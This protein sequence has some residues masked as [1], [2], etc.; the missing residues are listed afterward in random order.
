[1][2]PIRPIDAIAKKW[3]EVTPGRAAQYE[4]GVRNPVRNYEQNAAA[5]DPA[6]R[7]G[8]QAAIQR[9]SF[10]LGV[11]RAGT[12]K[13]QRKAIE[14]GPARYGPGV[15][16]AQQDYSAGFSPFRDVIERTNLPPRG[17]RRSPQ[18]MQR[19]AAMAAALG[20]AK[21]AQLRG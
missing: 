16:A 14:L 12:A 3:A 19:V 7:A 15:A 20:A 6:W 4:A 13:W 11:R 8:V 5:A 10:V 2:P 18:N 17:P 1:M 9:N 21:E